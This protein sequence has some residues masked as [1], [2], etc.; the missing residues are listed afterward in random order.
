LHARTGNML[1]FWTEAGGSTTGFR[2]GKESH[3]VTAL[4][5]DDDGNV[6][7]G[8]QKVGG[9]SAGASCSGADSSCCC[10]PPPLA[11]VDPAGGGC[12]AV[13]MP[14]MRCG[15]AVSVGGCV[16]AQCYR[17]DTCLCTVP[18]L[19]FSPSVPLGGGDWE[20]MRALAVTGT[21]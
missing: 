21:M 20:H 7:S 4:G 17:M 8:H 11:P 18:H 1:E 3:T 5:I 12:C 2:M 14:E 13:A 15:H 16:K 6:W 10:C 9:R 19:V